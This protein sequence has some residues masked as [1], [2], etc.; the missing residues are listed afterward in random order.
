MKLYEFFESQFIDYD[1]INLDEMSKEELEELKLK[2]RKQPFM[3]PNDMQW[4]GKIDRALIGFDTH[5]IK[6]GKLKKSKRVTP[7]NRKRT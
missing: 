1:N 6:T 2:I 5:G 7:F 4:L 3:D